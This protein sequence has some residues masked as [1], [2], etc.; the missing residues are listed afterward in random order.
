ME[1]EIYRHDIL[2]HN[3]S[4]MIWFLIPKGEKVIDYLRKN[5]ICPYCGC[6]HGC[7]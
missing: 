7:E 5:R 1:K 2:C 4:T 6:E 3:C